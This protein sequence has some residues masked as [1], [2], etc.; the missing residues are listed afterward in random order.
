[1][2]RS[3]LSTIPAGIAWGTSVLFSPFLVPIATAVGVVQKYADPQDAL[4]WLVIVVVFITVLPVLSIALMV[5]SAKVSDF[6]LQNREEL[7]PTFMLYAR[8]YD[9]RHGFTPP[10]RCSPRNRLGRRCLRRE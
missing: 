4:R 1:M 5:R 6:H 3:N 8:Q 7:T 9:C 2:T 10:T